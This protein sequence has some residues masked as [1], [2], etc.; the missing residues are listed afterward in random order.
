MRHQGSPQMD[1]DEQVLQQSAVYRYEIQVRASEAQTSLLPRMQ[2]LLL[3]LSDDVLMETA[4]SPLQS[5]F[6][7]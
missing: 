3:L 6:D 1:H 5:Y 7:V 4:S 2:L